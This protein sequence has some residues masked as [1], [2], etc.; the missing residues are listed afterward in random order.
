MTAGMILNALL[1]ARD[2]AHAALLAPGR[3]P[4]TYG[5]FASLCAETAASLR[6][7]GLARNDKLAIVLPNGPDMAAS[8]IACAC[9]VT[10]AP[11]N[12]AYREEEFHFYMEDLHARALLVEEGSASPA[13]AAAHRLGI[14]ILTLNSARE[15]GAFSITG[16]AAGPPLP[17]DL[18]EGTDVALVLHT[19]GTTSRP[20]IVP[21]THANLLASANNICSTLRLTEEDRCLNIMPLFHIHGLVAAILATLAAGGSVFATPGFN[22]LKFFGWMEEAHPSWYTAVPTMHQTILQRAERNHAIIASNPLRFI[23]SSS[24]SLPVPVFHALEEAFHCP[25]IEAYAMTENA[26]QMTSNQLPPGLRKPGFVGRAA[27]PEVAVMSTS[28]KLLGAGEEGEVV[29]RGP[30]VTPGYENNPKANDDGFAFGWFHTGDQG[31]MDEDGYLKITGRLKEIINRGGE[32]IAPMEVD[33][34]LMEHEAVAQVVTFAM[35]HNLLGEEVA[36][37]I[38]LREGRHVNERELQDFANQRLAGF[39]VPKRIII[40]D[41]IPKGATGKLQRIGLAQKLGLT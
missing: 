16:E 32:K 19:S 35:P 31:F 40:L 18:A 37:A 25:V 2:P 33:E 34:V 4:L 27:G 14:P 15:A 38:V 21:L 5:L 12:P 11:L 30:N 1:T 28:G 10:A 26:H 39:K 36:A 23:R 9:A 24:A 8:F 29:T 7:L 20:K 13:I 17:Q 6:A 41:E 3:A 22:A